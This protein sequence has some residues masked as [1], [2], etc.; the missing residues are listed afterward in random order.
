MMRIYAYGNEM[1][2]DDRFFLD[3]PGSLADLER[4][5]ASLYPGVVLNVQEEFEV[6]AVLEF[7]AARKIWLGNP[8]WG[9]RRDL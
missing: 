5:R 4:H 2:D 3:I 7:D 9:T 1:T 6:E 8:D